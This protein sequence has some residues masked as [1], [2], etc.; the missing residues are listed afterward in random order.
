MLTKLYLSKNN[1]KLLVV[2][3]YVDDI[4]FGTINETLCRDFAKLIQE[5]FEMSLMGELNYFIGL[6]V[7]QTNDG[8][9]IRQI[10]YIKKIIK[11]FGMES[12]KELNTPL[13]PTYKLDKDEEGINIDQK[14]YRRIIGSL[15]YLTASRPD[16]LFSICICAIFQSNPKEHICLLLKEL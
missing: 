6:Q 3:I 13:S 9:F 11:K 12:S 15:L 5:E 4:I 2:Q 16:I 7:K 8:I 14:L 1:N 10:K